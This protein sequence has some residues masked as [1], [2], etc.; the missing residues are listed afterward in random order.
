MTCIGRRGIEMKRPHCAQERRR[1]V[2]LN[3]DLGSLSHHSFDISEGESV[4]FQ[5]FAGLG[6]TV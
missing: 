2:S 6:A 5:R 4:F 1:A 3:A